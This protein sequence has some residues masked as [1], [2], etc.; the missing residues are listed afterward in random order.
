MG[1]NKGKKTGGADPALRRDA[2]GD[3]LPVFDSTLGYLWVDPNRS[4]KWMWAAAAAVLAYA[5]AILLV[6]SQAAD[7]GFFTYQG[8]PILGVDSGSP[9][10]EAGVE[11]GD[12]IVAIN[13]TP[14]AD[15]YAQASALTSIEAGELVALT[16]ER[17]DQTLEMTFVAG[18]TL[19]L[20]SAA[21]IL[22]AVLLLLIAVMADRGTPGSLPRLFF[23]S[24]LVYIVF[25]AGAFSV[26]T[27]LRLSLLAIPWVFGLVLAA[28]VTCHFMLRFPAG[29]AELSKKALFALYAPP[30]LLG[31]MLAIKH[32]SFVIGHAATAHD[33]LSL[34]FGVVVAA[35]AALY[36][37][38]GAVARFKRLRRKRDEIDPVAAK[39]LHI[40]GISIALPLILATIWALRDL[41]AFVSGGFR[42]FVAVAMIGGAGC[43]T[44]A[45]TRTPF[46]QLDRVWRRSG[47]YFLATTAAAAIYL[48][49]IG[50]LGG[51]V[52]VLTGGEFRAALAATLAAAVVFGPL[53]VHL[54]K[55]VDR[56][57]ARDRSLARSLLREAAEAAATTLDIDILQSGVAH[58]VRAALNA[59]G[60]AVYVADGEGGWRREAI[61]GRVAIRERLPSSHR[62]SQRLDRAFTARSARAV[63]GPILAVP[64]PVDGG[65]AAALVVMPRDGHTFND[66][67]RELLTTVAAQFVVAIGNARAHRQ[68]QKLTEKLQKEVE[69]AERR[70]REIARLKERV[71]EE[72]RALIGQLASRSGHAPVIGKGLKATFELAQKV[73]HSDASVL[74][75]G[76]TG[77]G[78]ELVAR[79]I[80]AA[81]PRRDGPFI[82]V[83]CG[84]I[85]AGVFESALF[86][87]ERGAFTGAVR[88]TQGA[89]RAADGG[90]I[91]LDEMGE[92]P[93]DLQPKLLRVLQE[94]EVHPVGGDKPVPVDV[95]VVAGTNRHL[96][97]EV[98]RGNFREDL[99]Y[100]LQVV[101]IEIPPLRKRRGDIPALAEHFLSL[102]ASRSG[103]VVKR[104]APDAMSALVDHEWPGNVRELENALEAAAVYAQSDEIRASDLPIFEDVFRKKGKRA[105]SENGVQNG[106]GAPKKGLRETLEVLERDRLIEALREQNG[107][108]TRTAKALGMSRGALLRRLKRYDISNEDIDNASAA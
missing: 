79:A 48:A 105:I 70:R 21:G 101:E 63:R 104:L 55:I 90:T 64:I 98:R 7:L 28:P 59:E 106:D 20:A 16:V 102:H 93:L 76:E 46:G 31:S 108:K 26:G 25:L 67:E 80:H 47:G 44:L 36:L 41:R 34:W 107:N 32:L 89:F 86:G 4:R 87:H 45:M 19:P 78:K 91:F 95:R 38:I 33:R 103:R 96:S 88:S 2:A 17:G 13:G 82:V 92:L 1:S 60:C 39:W 24:T 49:F 22:V 5:V 52:S 40:G 77:V 99:L 50:L 14:T 97:D 74:V 54:Q 6:A 51:T 84:A 75:R 12:M 29:R 27:A 8:S 53:R 9:A 30:L 15:P 42:P 3:S 69:I 100:R 58:R 62:I 56:R 71:E 23:R 57:F 72:N 37:S 85:S 10:A 61:A 81:S 73:P 43:V 11:P 68:L 83:D 18:R 94:R 35:M 66:E 65:N